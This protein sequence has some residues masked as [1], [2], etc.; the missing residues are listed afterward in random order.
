MDD[1]VNDMLDH[2]FRNKG[3][4]KSRFLLNYD[5]Q[6]LDLDPRS[7]EHVASDLYPSL[8]NSWIRDSNIGTDKLIS[9]AFNNMSVG[10][11]S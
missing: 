4:F 11:P 6:S 7:Q 5:Y 8:E 10:L 3:L 9:V 2:P 1:C